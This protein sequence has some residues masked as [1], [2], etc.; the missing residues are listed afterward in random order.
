M[1][2]AKLERVIAH[3]RNTLRGYYCLMVFVLGVTLAMLVLVNLSGRL[4]VIGEKVAGNLVA[5]FFGT[6]SLPSLNEIQK[7]RDRVLRLQLLKDDYA[8]RS[9]GDVMVFK[10]LE[11]RIDQSIDDVLKG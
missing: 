3:L 1:C 6:L 11:Q 10:E 9:D 4:A 7:R 5:A 2:H 8:A